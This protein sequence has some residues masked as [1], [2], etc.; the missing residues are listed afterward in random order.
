MK[1]P[2]FSEALCKEI[3]VEFFFYGDTKTP[4]SEQHM[5]RKLCNSCPVYDACLEWALHHEKHGIWAGTNETE[6]R[7]LRSK[8]KI[9][10][11]AILMEDYL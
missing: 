9:K 6:R 11:Q 5:A 10:Y 2:D 8:R 7:Y 4:N 3:G 1:Y